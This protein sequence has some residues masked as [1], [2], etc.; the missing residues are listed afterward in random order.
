MPVEIVP[1]ITS[2]L[3]APALANVPVTHRGI[4]SSF[5]VVSG[6]AGGCN[7]TQWS[8][9]GT[10]AYGIA[11]YQKMGTNLSMLRALRLSRTRVR[12]EREELETYHDRIRETTYRAIPAERREW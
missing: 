3:S 11:S 10:P 1:G 6:V 12:D 4:T 2:A 7:P 5:A 9:N 8:I